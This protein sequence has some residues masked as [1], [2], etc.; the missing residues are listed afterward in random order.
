MAKRSS[1]EESIL[2]A[3]QA[4]TASSSSD[5]LAP[6]RRLSILR[7]LL[8]KYSKKTDLKNGDLIKWKAGLKNKKRPDYDEFAMVIEVL[9]DPVRVDDESSGSPYFR[10]ALDIRAALV[11]EDGELLFYYFD[12]N[13]FEKYEIQND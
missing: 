6:R 2:Q 13:R 7:E 9:E 3:L 8:E 11:D 10:E 5:G 1:R 4:L 12:S